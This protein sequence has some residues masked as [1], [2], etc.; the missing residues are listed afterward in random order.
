MHH[1][2]AIVGGMPKPTA[3]PRVALHFQIPETV[4]AILD[5]MAKEAT[6]IGLA[7]RSSVA[8]YLVT[9]HPEMVRRLATGAPLAN[10]VAV[11]ASPTVPCLASPD[12]VRL[13]AAM[14][15]TGLGT[16]Y[17][18]G[19]ASGVDKSAVARVLEGAWPLK[20]TG[21]GKLLA[22]VEGVEAQP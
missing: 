8:L 13:Q 1:A 5:A 4:S 19:K 22:W 3:E 9:T 2:V 11:T 17:A 14:A 7:S 12:V 10:G 16:A 18:V 6:G 20:T 21:K 15:R